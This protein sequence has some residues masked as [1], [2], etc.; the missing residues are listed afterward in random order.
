MNIALI[1]IFVALGGLVGFLAG[2]LG[3]GGGM[4]IVPVLAVLFSREGFEAAHVL[5]LAIGTACA[6]I[7]FTSVSSAR[8][9][10]SRKAVDWQIVK[11]MAPGLVVGS[12]IGPQIAT[13]LPPRVLA[14]VFGIFMWFTAARMLRN[15]QPKPSGKLPAT[16]MLF[17]VGIAIGVVSGMVGAG[18]AFLIVPFLVRA[19]VK[20]HAAVGTSAA[21]GLPIAIA[22]TLGYV[23]AGVRMEGLPPY[24]IGYVYLPAFAA[25]VVA[26]VLF[27]PMGARVAH[28]WP[29]AKL[30]RSFAAMMFLLGIYMWWRAFGG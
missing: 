8:A 9:H 17:G 2:L 19:N 21:L 15:S 24:S 7:V 14:V 12:I 10:H 28:S 16:P 5:P 30:R 18:G 11:A 22:A 20:M 3:I 1:P 29:V 27:A 6:T 13:A 25:I 23:I 26:S 4:T